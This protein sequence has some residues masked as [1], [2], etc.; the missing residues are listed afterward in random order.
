MK[1]SIELVRNW[2]TYDPLEGVLIRKL[3]TSSRL[4]DKVPIDKRLWFLGVRYPYSH[5]IW[6]V[7]FGK[8]PDVYI[9]HKDHNQLNFKLDNLREAT[10]SQNQHNKRMNNPL[11]KGV[12]Y[13]RSTYRTR[14]WI[15][16]I[17][18]NNQSIFLGSY[19]TSEEAAKA[20]ADAAH[21]YHGEFAC[22]D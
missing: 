13:D 2:F 11:G 8:W 1:P 10:E 18:V 17:M 5:I 22:L 12:A 3:K 15:A 6:V 16:R 7:H 9:D 4:E 20:Y 19:A 21:K 14:P